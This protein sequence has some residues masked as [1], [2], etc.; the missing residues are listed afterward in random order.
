MNNEIAVI[1]TPKH[2]GEIVDLP[3]ILYPCPQGVSMPFYSAGAGSSM[4]LSPVAIT[5]SAAFCSR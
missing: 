5:S 1:M 4:V 2:G 3:T